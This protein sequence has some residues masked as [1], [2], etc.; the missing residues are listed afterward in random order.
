MK[1]KINIMPAKPSYINLECNDFMDTIA[2]QRIL[3]A[4][5]KNPLL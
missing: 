4:E 2:I 5:R 3:V 1:L